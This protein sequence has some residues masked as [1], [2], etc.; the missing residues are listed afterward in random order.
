MIQSYLMPH[1]I[2]SSVALFGML[3]TGC[4]PN[5][6]MVGQ[7]ALW[8]GLDKNGGLYN[9]ELAD[10]SQHSFQSGEELRQT[11]WDHEGRQIEDGDKYYTWDGPCLTAI[12]VSTDSV[13]NVTEFGCDEWGWPIHAVQ[14]LSYPD[15]DIDPTLIETSYQNVYE[16]GLLARRTITDTD[17]D[18]TTQQFVWSGQRLQNIATAPPSPALVVQYQWRKDGW[19]QSLVESN[20]DWE[21]SYIYIYDEH[22]R[23]EGTQRISNNDIDIA[24]GSQLTTQRW[25]YD[26]NAQWPNRWMLGYP[27]VE[28]EFELEYRCD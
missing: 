26:D 2:L 27:D 21:S 5:A 11:V 25:A 19:I 28:R 4:S 23:L 1:Q 22:D 13:T 17:G 16:D 20:G 8:R 14:T 9:P 18:T 10:C 24:K 12:D 6:Y 15:Y 3:L 7:T